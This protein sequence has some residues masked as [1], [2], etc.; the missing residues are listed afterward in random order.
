MIVSFANQGTEDIYDGADT[1]AARQTLP[2]ELWSVAR[3]KLDLLHAA[4]SLHDLKAPPSNQ[5]EK[6]KKEYAGKHSIRVNDQYRVIF[7]F[8]DG[9]AAGVMITDP[10]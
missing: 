5:L 2:K 8:G 1:K 7:E 9:T 10:H 3:R 6:L 4:H